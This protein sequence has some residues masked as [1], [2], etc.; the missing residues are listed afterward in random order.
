ME[1]ALLDWLPCQ[2][3]AGLARIA[4]ISTVTSLTSLHIF[5]WIARI[6]RPSSGWIRCN[7]QETSDFAPT[8]CV[9]YNR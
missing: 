3:F 1:S 9:G 8:N 6:S 7:W 2:R 5:T 4:S